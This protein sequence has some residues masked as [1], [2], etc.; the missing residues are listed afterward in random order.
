MSI[1]SDDQTLLENHI[2]NPSNE[3]MNHALSTSNH[4]NENNIYDKVPTKRNRKDIISQEKQ[5]SKLRSQ[6]REIQSKLLEFS[7][8]HNHKKQVLKDQ[9]TRSRK[10]YEAFADQRADNITL[11]KKLEF[12]KKSLKSQKIK[13]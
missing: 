13:S 11:I 3:Y 12:E 9:L 6:I 5:L 10:D 4:M 7:S 1:S 2:A 8:S